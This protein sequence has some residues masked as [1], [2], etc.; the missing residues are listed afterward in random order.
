MVPQ[1][2]GKTALLLIDIQRGLV[3]APEG[4]YQAEAIVARCAD[5]LRRAR[6]AAIPIF[7]VQHDG[8][9][10]DDLERLSP[11]WQ[12]HESVMPVSGEPVTE[13][14]T[15]SAF[16]S[17]ELDRRLHDAGITRLVIAG[18]QTDYCIDTNCRVARNLGYD[19]TL[20]ADA[21][22]TCDGGELNAAQIIAHHNRILGSSTVTLRP[23]A[24]IVF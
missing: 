13:K 23:A 2:D 5:L 6:A 16:I 3:E 20:A 17:G 15:S 19:V 12:L 10:G 14:A 18:L 24:E 7:H 11:G 22:S 8:G 9:A 1:A 4:L 21:H